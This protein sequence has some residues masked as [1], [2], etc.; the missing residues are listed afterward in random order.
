MRVYSRSRLWQWFFI[1][2]ALEAGAAFIAL[3]RV[4]GEAGGFS[5]PRLGM[6]GLLGLLAAAA[7]YAAVRQPRWVDVAARPGFTLGGFGAAFV[8]A[9]TLFLL[10]YV[11]PEQS[12]Q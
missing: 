11:A 6:L 1:L 3:V 2:A 10:R 12:L 8:V 9:V 7:I 5:A 4:P